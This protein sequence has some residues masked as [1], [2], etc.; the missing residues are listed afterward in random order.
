MNC[1]GGGSFGLD[2]QRI[3]MA[4]ATNKTFN[5]TNY[6]YDCAGLELLYG[7]TYTTLVY[8]SGFGSGPLLGSCN[9]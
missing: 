1:D 6:Y 4:G 7:R 2:A 9:A 5:H 3:G 8:A